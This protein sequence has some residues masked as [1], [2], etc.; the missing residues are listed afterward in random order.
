MFES[1]TIQFTE[2]EDKQEILTFEKLNQGSL[3][4][5][6]YDLT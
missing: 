3:Y 2:M 4:L 6:W 5:G 1:K